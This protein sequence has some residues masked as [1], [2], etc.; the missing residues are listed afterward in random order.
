MCTTCGCGSGDEGHE[1]AEG[2]VDSHVHRHEHV[3]AQVHAQAHDHAGSSEHPRHDGVH[4]HTHGPGLGHGH[5]HDDGAAHPHAEDHAHEPDGAATRT[6]TLEREL[7]AKNAR[8]AASNRRLFAQR[9]LS[10]F[11][12]IGSPGAGKT[13]LLEALIR[14][15]RGEIEMAV[16]EGDQATDRDAMRIEG[17]GCRVMQIN[18]GTGCH[19]DAS[20]VERGLVALAPPR[21]SAVFIENV[22]NLVCPALFDLGE[23]AKVVVMSVTEGEDKPLKYP[24]VFRAARLFVL[25]KI[26]LLPHLAFDE[27]RCLGYAREVAGP[28]LA[29]V[30]VSATTGEG[31]EALAGWV[32]EEVARSDLRGARVHEGAA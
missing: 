15:T 4:A 28:E 24:H 8:L 13:A 9:R 30:R 25:T 12:L 5:R 26:D 22:G 16:L 10:V 31:I 3:R 20:M 6:V 21:G 17:A 11:N 7:L 14:R 1:H 32:R 2:R 23:Q 27:R 29:V 19:L 18:T